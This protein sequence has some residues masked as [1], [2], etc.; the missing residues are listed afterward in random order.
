MTIKIVDDQR[1]NGRGDV[2]IENGAG[3]WM[4]HFPGTPGELPP[5]C[6]TDR[7]RYGVENQFPNI[8]A[9]QSSHLLEFAVIITYSMIPA[10]R[11]GYSP[12]GK[13]A[14]CVSP[15]DL[16]PT[17]QSPTEHFINREDWRLLGTSQHYGSPN[18][19]MSKSQWEDWKQFPAEVYEWAL[20]QYEYI[21]PM[22]PPSMQSLV[23]HRKRTARTY[24][25]RYKAHENE[26][27]Q[28]QDQIAA[29]LLRRDEFFAKMGQ[30]A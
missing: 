14:V 10:P 25:E 9:K 19:M 7:Y 12:T 28:V 11:G 4:V 1:V 20:A 6:G 21:E 22:V 29:A 27:L 8:I 16:H 24:W 26:Y 30:P 13:I 17:G 2:R 18:R 5:N 23:V 3:V 15:M